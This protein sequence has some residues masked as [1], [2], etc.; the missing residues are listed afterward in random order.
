MKRIQTTKIV[1]CFF[2]LLTIS[3]V[4]GQINPSDGR[5]ILYKLDSNGMHG[6]Q[7]K[8]VFCISSESP[9]KGKTSLVVIGDTFSVES[10]GAMCWVTMT[11]ADILQTHFD[12][13]QTNGVVQIKMWTDVYGLPFPEHTKLVFNNSVVELSKVKIEPPGETNAKVYEGKDAL[14]QMKK[15]G[16]ELPEDMDMEK[17]GGRRKQN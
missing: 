4:R 2:V 14:R 10:H 11:N 16:L 12:R 9:E 1:L 8:Y 7:E 13:S 15:M 17:A 6:I 5:L 3:V